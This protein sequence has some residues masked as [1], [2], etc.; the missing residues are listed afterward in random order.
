MS[1]GVEPQ[2]QVPSAESPVVL[3]EFRQVGS[4]AV[5]QILL[6]RPAARNAITVDLGAALEAA[7]RA[8][9]EQA[10]VVVVRGAGGNFCAG[11]DLHEVSRLREQGPA[12]LRPLFANWVAACQ[13]IAELPVP[14]VAAV[15]GYALAGGFELLSSVDIA[16]VR[17][18]AVLADNHVNFG[19]LPSAGGSQRLPRLVG[20]PRAMGHILTGERLS[21]TQAAAWGLVY[22]SV[23]PDA[24]ERTL[25]ELLTRLC[26]KDRQTLASTKQLVHAGLRT[27]LEEGLALETDATIE[28]LAQQEA[29]VAGI[30]NF[31]SK[32]AR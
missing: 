17:D 23:T 12:A 8:G 11:G 18:D 13:A 6:N 16:V 29:A 2:Q 26:D 9:A 27:S 4:G 24:F 14:V 25:E 28:H 5:W 3:T 20:L 10:D 1:Y 21:G 15:E 30:A 31:T 32:G 19:I 22:R 7:L